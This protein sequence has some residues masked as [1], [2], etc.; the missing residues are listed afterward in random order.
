MITAMQL[1]QATERFEKMT[2][3]LRRLGTTFSKTEAAEIVGGHARLMKLIR[4]GKIHVDRPSWDSDDFGSN[5]R[6]RCLAADVLE[7]ISHKIRI[8]R[9]YKN[10]TI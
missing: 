6:W 4:E 1:D 10:Q 3:T 5:S 2:M 7:N 9:T 8:K